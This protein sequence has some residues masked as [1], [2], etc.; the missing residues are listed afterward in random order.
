MDEGSVD[1]TLAL[2]NPRV[3]ALLVELADLL[4]IKGDST[5]KSNAYRRA[6]DAVARSPVELLAAYRAGDPPTLP[7]VGKGIAYKL[8]ELARSGRIGELEELRAA[9]PPGVVAMLRLTGVGPRTAGEL[10]RSRGIASLEELEAAAH[11]GR[12]RGVRGIGAEREARI[13]EAIEQH[14]RRPSRRLLMGE[15]NALAERI[16]ALAESVPEVRSATIAGSTRRGTETVGDLDLL[17]ETDD[18]ATALSRLLAALPHEG[19][20]S[21]AEPLTLGAARASLALREGPQLDIMTAPP[22]RLGSYLVHLTGSAAHNVRLRQRAKQRG[23]SLSEHGLVPLDASAPEAVDTP[24]LET[25]ANEADLYTWLGLAAVEPELREDRGEVE[26][27]AEDRL[28]RLVTRADLIGDCHSHT[29]WSDGR[30]PLEHM[31]ESARAMGQRWL[32][33]TDH[34]WSLT[35][36]NGLAPDR[37]ELQRRVI[38]DLN[39]RFASEVARGEA[40]EGA[41]P[42]FRLLHGCEL[43]IT[44]D[45]RLDY[46]DAILERFDVVVASLHVGRRQP[47]AQLM[48][49][50]EAAL[51]SP[52]VDILAHPS[53]RKIGL[54]PDLDLDWDRF[55]RRAAETG[56]FLEVN[57]SPPRL[58]L[59]EERIRAAREAGCRFTIDSDAHDPVEWQHLVWGATIA[60]RAWLEPDLVANTRP[61]EAFLALI[62]ERSRAG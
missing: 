55:Y 6:A 53:G 43:E 5:F 9:T 50:Y 28:P 46:D 44:I 3:A 35:I 4:D 26:A 45:G 40:P 36:A 29:D 2:T 47:R 38:G 37:V 25:F 7:G 13:L 31:V 42:D 59:D 8:E 22:G 34:S 18:P 14:R 54:R 30:K 48:A 61:L 39:E 24:D 27:A 1:A 17:V 60:R 16:V 33:L 12:L 11:D 23:R 49:R 21:S 41:H 51:R 58:D 20:G 62:E 57:G 15:A 10:W 32:V 56:T 52:H 19:D